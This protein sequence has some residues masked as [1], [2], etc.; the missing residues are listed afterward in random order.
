M[1][2]ITWNCNMAFRRKA[3]LLL[4]FNPDIV[5]IPECEHF[6]KLTFSAP[7]LKPSQSVWFGQ[8][9]NKGLGIFSYS[10][11]KIRVLGSHN[12]KFQMVIPV[13]VK[14]KQSR[15]NLFAIWA[16][17]PRD[18]DGQYVTQVWKAIK[19]YDRI[20][21]KRGT[22]L[23]G[24][25]NSNTIWDKPHREGKHSAVVNWLEE[26]GICSVYHRHFNQA[27]GSEKH[28]TLYMYRHK[29]K[30]YHIDYCFASGDMMDRL[31]SVEVGDYEYWRQFSDHMPMIVNF[32]SE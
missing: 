15:F 26:K 19:Y 25:F 6:D 32:R 3:H 20:I 4:Q 7:A 24:D 30:S 18:P 17:N 2:V 1:K 10:D 21:R 31:E 8:N 13:A 5:V 11:Y 29:E 9:R 16:N 12:E 22:M 23:I 27:Q 14:N 28:P